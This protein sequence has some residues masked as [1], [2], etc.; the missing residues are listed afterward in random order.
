M[1]NLKRTFAI[2]LIFFV[3]MQSL[4]SFVI[5]GLFQINRHKIAQEQCKNRFD[6]ISTCYGSCVLQQQ[7]NEKAEEDAQFPPVTELQ[8]S[9][10]DCFTAFVTLNELLEETYQYPKNNLL[11]YKYKTV[12][13]IFH[14]PTRA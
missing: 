1:P 9:G 2:V 14:P 10:Y 6:K 7:L 8:L 13:F 4:Q 5:I 3:L 12:K 11:Q